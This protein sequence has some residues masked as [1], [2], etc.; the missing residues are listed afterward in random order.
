MNNQQLTINNYQS[1]QSFTLIEMLVVLGVM[2]LVLPVIFSMLFLTLRQQVKIYRLAEVKRQ[3]DSTTASIENAIKSYA[4][5]VRSTSVPGSEVCITPN[6][7]S[8][9]AAYFVDKFTNYFGYNLDL[10]YQLASVSAIPLAGGN[11]TNNKVVVSNLSFS[12]TKGQFYSAPTVSMSFN[13]CYKATS[14]C[15]SCPCASSRPE[16]QAML[17]YQSI[18]KLRSLP[19]F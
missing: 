10:N 2:G 18:I 17:N 16:E 7:S 13:I 3:G 11:L 19:T 5:N 9:S 15:T 4:V 8:L 14:S 12:C 6:S 1:K